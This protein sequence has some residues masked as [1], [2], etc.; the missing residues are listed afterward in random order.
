[1]IEAHRRREA[2]WIEAD[3]PDLAGRTAARSLRQRLPATDLMRLAWKPLA[4]LVTFAGPR[5]KQE[6]RRGAVPPLRASTDPDVSG[7]RYWGP[8]GSVKGTP[9]PLDAPGTSQHRNDCG[10]WRKD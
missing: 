1:M 7:G 4:P 9:T 5:V 3:V 2:P 8:T 6:P 10:L